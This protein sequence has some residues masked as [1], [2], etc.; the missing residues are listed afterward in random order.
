MPWRRLT[1]LVASG[2]VIAAVGDGTGSCPAHSSRFR[3]GWDS[4]CHRHQPQ[5]LFSTCPRPG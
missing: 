1:K 5:T 3:R 2:A 4:K